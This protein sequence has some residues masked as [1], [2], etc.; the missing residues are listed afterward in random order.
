MALVDEQKEFTITLDTSQFDDGIYDL[1]GYISTRTGQ[2]SFDLPK[3]NVDTIPPVIEILSP[4]TNAEIS[5]LPTIYASYNDGTV[6][7]GINAKTSTIK[8]ARLIPT[9]EVVKL[10]SGGLKTNESALIY[11]QLTSLEGGLYRVTVAVSDMSGN[12]GETSIQF[13]IEGTPPEVPD[14]TAPVV[15]TF[16]PQGVVQSEDVL[17]SVIASDPESGVSGVTLS[18]DGKAAK[19]GAAQVFTLGDWVHKVKAVVTNG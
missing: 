10:D 2:I 18:I 15:S 8:L 4:L 3:I 13:A 5:P 7:S 6:G 14:N 9:E 12:L 19:E 1:K 11:T 17:V 16:S